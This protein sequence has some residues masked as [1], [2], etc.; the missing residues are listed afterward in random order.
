MTGTI[1]LTGASGQLGRAI[2]EELLLRVDPDRIVCVCRKPE[3][4]DEH[5]RVG[6]SVRAGD[7]DDPPSMIEAFAGVERLL[8]ISAV[9]ME[10]RVAQHRAAIDAAK[11][12]G[13]RHLAYTSILNPVEAN[14]AAAVPS[15]R[16]T[17]EALA[18]SGLEW[19][20]LRNGL[21]QETRVPSLQQAI[22]SGRYVHNGGDG[23]TAYVARADCAAAAAALLAGGGHEGEVVDLTGP[24]SLSGVD[25]AAIAAD[26]GGRPVEAVA[27]DD[28]MFAAGLVEHAGFPAP[29]AEQI[30]TFGRAIREGYLDG[31]SPAVRD[32]TG[33]APRTLRGLL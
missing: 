27:V 11:A 4:L 6:V 13:V 24:E 30:A 16:A 10:R 20:V 9:D 28:E 1:A 25:L 18:E 32:L 15:H 17:E 22:E 23:A 8:L 14:P 26:A 7:F 31:V 5:A 3:G 33:R 21:Y 29:V 2:V 12:V 19:T